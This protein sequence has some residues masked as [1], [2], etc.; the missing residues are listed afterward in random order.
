[1]ISAA[2][3]IEDDEVNDKLLINERQV[4]LISDLQQGS[5]IDALNTYEWPE[6]TELIVKPV[7]AK[8]TTNAAMQVMASSNYTT[9][10]DPNEQLRVRIINSS[11]A[12]AER[13]QLSWADFKSVDASVKPASVY[14]PP[15]ESVVTELP[16]GPN[17][18]I[19]RKLLLSG[20]GQ[21]YDN[22]LY[23]APN[24]VQ[25]V[26]ILYLGTDN[27]ENLAFLPMG[28]RSTTS[29]GTIAPYMV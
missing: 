20:D 14:V 24:L 19:G 1:M 27:S 25:Q 9:Q 18:I 17:D 7:V 22:T 21:D 4:I 3:A 10:S 29:C 28:I 15:G 2:E 23:L 26:N 6:N 16:A 12:S 13:F 11:D 8:K 5:D